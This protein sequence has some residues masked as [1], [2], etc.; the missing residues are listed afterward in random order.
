MQKVG[1]RF[2]IRRRAA[3]SFILPFVG[4]GHKH[5]PPVSSTI[6]LTGRRTIAILVH[7]RA[8]YGTTLNV[9]QQVRHR[10]KQSFHQFKN[11]APFPDFCATIWHI[12]SLYANY[13]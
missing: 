1:L 10:Y 13:I 4:I 5:L 9:A 12:S 8:K 7:S 6:Y 3:D 11:Q 2:T